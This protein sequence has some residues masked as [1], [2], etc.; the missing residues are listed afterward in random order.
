M[1]EQEVNYVCHIKYETECRAMA[2]SVTELFWPK[3]LL[4]DHGMMI[5]ADASVL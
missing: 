3:I 5:D 4:K 2:M 1:E